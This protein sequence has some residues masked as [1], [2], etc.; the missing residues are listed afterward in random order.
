MDAGSPLAA[1]T[2]RHELKTYLQ[3]R[4]DTFANPLVY[5][6]RGNQGPSIMTMSSALA[7]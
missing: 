4:L 1:F 3:R 5:T 2:A 7:Y 6:V